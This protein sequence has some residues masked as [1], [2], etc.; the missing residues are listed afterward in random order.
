MLVFFAVF[1]ENPAAL[2]KVPVL[3]DFSLFQ[4]DGIVLLAP[5]PFLEDPGQDLF[6]HELEEQFAAGFKRRVN[7]LQHGN[8]LT[9]LL[10]VSERRKQIDD[11][12]VGLRP[13]KVPCIFVYKLN[14]QSFRVSLCLRLVKVAR[15][16]VHARNPKAPPGQL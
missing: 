9:R 6:A 14:V 12:V 16:S 3:A 10:E 2:Y 15:R 8:V 13:T 11:G 1:E 5:I 7:I 4:E